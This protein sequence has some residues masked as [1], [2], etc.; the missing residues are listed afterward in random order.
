MPTRL[1]CRRGYGTIA[2]DYALQT[3]GPC[4][5]FAC[6][7]IGR[8]PSRIPYF[9]YYAIRSKI[10]QGKQWWIQLRIKRYWVGR[11]DGE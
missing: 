2:T 9:T 10:G 4:R 7:L 5:L 11:N 6:T 8:Y 1:Q 3:Q